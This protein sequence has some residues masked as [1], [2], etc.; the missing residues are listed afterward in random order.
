MIDIKRYS[1][2]DQDL[3]MLLDQK[4]T[5]R[6]ESRTADQGKNE[7]YPIPKHGSGERFVCGPIPYLWL[8]AALALGGKSANLAW[9]IWW[10]LGVE[11]SNGVRLTSRV[12][13]DF[14]ISP[15]TSR[16]LLKQLEQAGLVKVDRQRGRGPTVTVLP[17]PPLNTAE[18]IGDRTDSPRSNA[19][20]DP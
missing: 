17:S 7:G 19:R 10:L 4:R 2:T 16:R 18:T 8:Q 5:F 20:G 13:Q 1:E 3:R 6:S 15:R 11:R 12:L 9:A 14:D